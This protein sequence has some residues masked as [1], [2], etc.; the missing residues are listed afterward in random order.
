MGVDL[1]RNF[2]IEFEG[3][4]TFKDEKKTDYLRSKEYVCQPFY[5]GVSAFSEPE[6][7]AIRDFLVKKSFEVAINFLR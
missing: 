7:A 1:N 4:E 3:V 6:T 5:R 2:D